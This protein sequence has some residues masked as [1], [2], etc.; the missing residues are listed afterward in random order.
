VTLRNLAALLR[1][2]G[3]EEPAALLDAAA[4][5]APDAPPAAEPSRTVSRPAVS[6]PEALEVARAALHRHLG[7]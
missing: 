6:R 5:R 2:L 3:D 7:A 1:G 4:D